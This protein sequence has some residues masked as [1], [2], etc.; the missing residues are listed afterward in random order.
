MSQFFIRLPTNRTLVFNTNSF[1]KVANIKDEIFNREGIPTS[2][3]KLILSDKVLND[4]NLINMNDTNLIN[5][6]DT[7]LININERTIYLHFQT[8]GGVK[9]ATHVRRKNGQNTKRELAFRVPG[10]SDY[11]QIKSLKGDKRAIVLCLS[12]GKEYQSRIAGSLHQWI[13]RED[14]VLIGLR[15]FQQ[16]KADII[17]RYTPEEARK[18]MKAGEIQSSLKINDQ[19]LDRNNNNVEFIDSNGMNPDEDEDMLIQQKTY[20]LPPSESE[21]DNEVDVDDI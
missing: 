15:S 19:I 20:E 5:M 17:W 14:I 21:S 16:D 2:I 11:G 6:N 10:E 1:K 4:T 13:Q 3:Q 8:L 12:D 7:N 18:L 9:G